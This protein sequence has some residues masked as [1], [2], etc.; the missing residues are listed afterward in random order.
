M[1]GATCRRGAA[2]CALMTA[3]E[4]VRAIAEE[5]WQAKLEVS[6]LFASYLGDHRFDDRAD[7]LSAEAERQ[8]RDRWQEIRDRAAA[9]PADGLDDTDVVTR[10]LLINEL[11]DAVRGIE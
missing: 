1:P 9:I 2:R 6:P 8:V 4:Q 3:A 11:D 10:E 7:D 5:Y